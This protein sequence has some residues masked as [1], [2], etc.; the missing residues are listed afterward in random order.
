MDLITAAIVAAISSSMT[1]VGKEGVLDAYKAL[2]SLLS[3]KFGSHSP[4]AKA[5]EDLEHNP[6]SQART[7][8]LQEEA[9]KAKADQ[10]PEL[11]RIAY[12]L[13]Q[14]VNHSSVGQSNQV[15]YGNKNVQQ[16][17]GQNAYHV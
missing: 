10:D 1:E 17:A 2:K 3:R 9:A 6:S 7:A 5:V 8:V 15:A 11:Y 13:Y 14:Q 4:I 16:Q 12:T